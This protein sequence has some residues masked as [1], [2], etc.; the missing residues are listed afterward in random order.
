MLDK[1]S[2]GGNTGNYRLKRLSPSHI[3]RVVKVLTTSLQ[4]GGLESRISNL[5]GRVTEISLAIQD[6]RQDI[7]DIHREIRTSQRQI[8]L[9]MLGIGVAQT[10]LILTLI[11]RTTG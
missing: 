11:L 9:T 3:T 2:D 8:M 7:R 10:G 6:I 5:E 1:I 4:D